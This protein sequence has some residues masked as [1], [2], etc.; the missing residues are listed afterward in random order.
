VHI[1]F[2]ILLIGKPSNVQLNAVQ[3]CTVLT[4][5]GHALLSCSHTKFPS[6]LLSLLLISYPCLGLARTRYMIYTVYDRI[7]GCSPAKIPYIHHICTTLSLFLSPCTEF[8]ICT[9]PPLTF[10]LGREGCLGL[11]SPPSIIACP[12]GVVSFAWTVRSKPTVK[13]AEH[14]AYPVT[15]LFAH[16]CLH[17][18]SVLALWPAQEREAEE[19]PR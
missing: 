11:G 2:A 6:S 14:L 5:P 4:S 16:S 8:P 7:I 10:F 13:Q 17:S 18:F 12:R 9:F 15:D 19:G 3:V 1:V